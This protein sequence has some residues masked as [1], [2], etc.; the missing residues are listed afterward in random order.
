MKRR[1]FLQTGSLVSLPVLFGGLELSAITRSALFGMVNNG[2]DRVLVLIQ[3]NG[4]NDGLNMVIPIDQYQG[5]NA[6][7]PNLVIPESMVLKMKDTTG[8]HP[9]MTGMHTMFQEEK[10]AV[11]QSVGYPIRT[12][13]TSGPRI[14]GLQRL[15]PTNFWLQAGQEGILTTS[16]QAILMHIPTMIV[17]TLL[18]SPSVV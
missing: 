4:G 16:F 17:R 3:L 5:L 12:G 7:R 18:P 14:S 13:P 8:L 2:N 10:L 9:S 6:V 15:K 1:Q 11:V